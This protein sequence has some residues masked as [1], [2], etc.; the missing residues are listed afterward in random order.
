MT[1]TERLFRG[2]SDEFMS[3]DDPRDYGILFMNLSFK[4]AINS[5]PPIISDYKIITFGITVP[6]IE[7]I[8]NSNKYLEVKKSIKRYY[9]KR[10]CNSYC[11]RKA[12]KKFKI[13]N[14]ISFH[15]SIRRADNFRTQQDLITKIYPEYGKL[16]SFHVRGDMPTSDRA[17]QMREFAKGKGLMTNARCLTEGVDLPA[18]DCVCFH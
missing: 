15:R 5:K 8:Y 11:L 3:M 17:T 12:I 10:A 6:E 9:S 4:E 13:N 1:A 16:K 18:I 2:D 7:E 14:A